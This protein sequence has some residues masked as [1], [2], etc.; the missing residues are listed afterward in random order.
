M[1]AH[2]SSSEGR[3]KLIDDVLS[4]AETTIRFIAEGVSGSGVPGLESA[5]KTILGIISQIKVLFHRC[6]R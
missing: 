2:G 6:E 4:G 1:S 3:A 5:A